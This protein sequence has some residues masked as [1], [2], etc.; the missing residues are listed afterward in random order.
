MQ[1]LIS[2]RAPI[3][4][5]QDKKFTKYSQ[6]KR[7]FFL[8]KAPPRVYTSLNIKER[9]AHK[10]GGKEE[11]NASICIKPHARRLRA[12]GNARHT[13]HGRGE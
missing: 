10:T 3:E 13:G 1:D 11:K 12:H 7:N 5:L 8:T 4:A 2:R 6:T 9:K